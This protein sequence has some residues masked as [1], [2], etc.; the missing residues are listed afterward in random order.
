MLP[1][2]SKNTNELKTS[3]PG[4]FGIDVSTLDLPMGTRILGHEYAGP[5]VLRKRSI[6]R[7]HWMPKG[8]NCPRKA[9]WRRHSNTRSSWAYFEN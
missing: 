5:A 4:R 7:Y 8:L 1:V 2:V 9:M 6:S 3:S